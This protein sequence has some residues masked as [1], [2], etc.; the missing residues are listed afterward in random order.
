MVRAIVGPIA[1]VN[2]YVPPLPD[3]FLWIC[4]GNCGKIWTSYEVIVTFREL[5]MSR[6]GWSVEMQS[7]LL[8][9]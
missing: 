2:L 8:M 1:V 5:K 7:R 9:M 4:V 3:P 6:T